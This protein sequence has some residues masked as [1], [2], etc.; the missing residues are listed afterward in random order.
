MRSTYTNLDTSTRASDYSVNVTRSTLRDNIVRQTGTPEGMPCKANEF[1]YLILQL[2]VT[3]LLRMCSS[4]DLAVFKTIMLSKPFSPINSLVSCLAQLWT[5][6]ESNHPKDSASIL[7]QPWN[8]LA[9]IAD[10]ALPIMD[11]TK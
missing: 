10:H 5:R 9:Q 2:R 1:L 8:M 4:C 3:P 7:R 11:L 6:V